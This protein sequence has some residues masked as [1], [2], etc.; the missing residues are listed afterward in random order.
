MGIVDYGSNTYWL[1]GQSRMEEWLNLKAV[2]RNF[3]NMFDRVDLGII[4]YRE[5]WVDYLS[6]HFEHISTTTDFQ[7]GW[8]S[9]IGAEIG[10]YYLSKLIL[11][12]ICNAFG[13]D[14]VFIYF[15]LVPD[16]CLC[17]KRGQ[18]NWNDWSKQVLSLGLGR[19]YRG[20]LLV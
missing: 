3:S 5:D 12:T 17:I 15:V 9:W 8:K 18:N 1:P 2:E 10:K 7:E 20:I 13:T 19:V 11:N 14:L 4:E 6:F 16:F